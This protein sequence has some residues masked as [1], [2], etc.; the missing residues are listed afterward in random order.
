MK[1]KCINNR[2]LPWGENLTVGKVY[3][4]LEKM[5]G[6]HV[7]IQNDNG[8]CTGYLN[9]RFEEVAST[10]EEQ[11]QSAKLRVSELE[12][13]IE[14]RKPKIGQKYRHRTGSIWMIV[15]VA[16]GFA[17]ICIEDNINS[18]TGKAYGDIRLNINDVFDGFNDNFTL[19]P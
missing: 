16:R 7:C 9:H 15:R 4:V 8:V 12:S 14:A 13:Q 11:L 1:V 19:L 3:E 2:D 6:D 17:L 10:L 5:N 18:E